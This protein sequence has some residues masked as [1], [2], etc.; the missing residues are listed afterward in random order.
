MRPSQPLN[1]NRDCVDIRATLHVPHEASQSGSVW[2]G[3]RP[4]TD[5]V[6][7]TRSVLL[8]SWV[9]S[10]QVTYKLFI[11]SA[12][13]KSKIERWSLMVSIPTPTVPLTFEA[14]SKFFLAICLVVNQYGTILVG[15]N[16]PLA[17]FS[18]NSNLAIFRGRLGRPD[19]RIPVV[20]YYMSASQT[21]TACM[22]T[23]RIP[24]AFMVFASTCRR[25]PL[26]RIW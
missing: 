5:D 15:S 2:E 8:S 25:S 13:I 20:L 24:L 6:G 10:S 16:V 17:C 19:C 12:S 18:P 3:G 9:S 7:N 4:R 26:K 1:P 23:S 22:P 11:L 21:Q 14:A